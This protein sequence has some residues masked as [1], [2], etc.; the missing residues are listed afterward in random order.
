[1]AQEQS[2]DAV[3][4]AARDTESL[5]RFGQVR[6]RPAL[7]AIQGPNHWLRAVEFG[8]AGIWDR[9]KHIFDRFHKDEDKGGQG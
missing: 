5:E 3:A 6:G 8:G 4:F 9:V 7:E 2:L 1:M